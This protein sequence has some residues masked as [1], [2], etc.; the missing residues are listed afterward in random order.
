MSVERIACEDGDVAQ[1]K[2]EKCS[3]NW[4]D[5]DE[6]HV[7]PISKD[8]LTFP[9]ARIK[10]RD[11]TPHYCFNDNEDDHSLRT[12]AVTQTQR[13][14]T[15]RNPMNR[16]EL[17]G[18]F[19]DEWNVGGSPGPQDV[20]PVP[21]NVDVNYIIRTA[22]SEA[23]A[24]RI[25]ENMNVNRPF[26]FGEVGDLVEHG[27]GIVARRFAEDTILKYEQ[28]DVINNP[29]GSTFFP[30]FYPVEFVTLVHNG[31]DELATRYLNASLE[32]G[33]L[34]APP[35]TEPRLQWFH[36]VALNQLLRGAGQGRYPLVQQ[37]A[38]MYYEMHVKP[39]EVLENVSHDSVEAWKRYN[40]VWVADQLRR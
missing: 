14:A 8:P 28:H 22:R 13:R 10:L 11:G 26:Y 23:E 21:Q 29:R 34:M 17:N 38:Q 20:E 33:S 24:L 18:P 35:S 37:A 32:H 16:D 12:M 31:F 30:Q 19:P 4:V 6:D 40:R 25:F 3:L 2:T 36:R 9:L 27:F 1:C 39:H 5:L 15:V 7:D